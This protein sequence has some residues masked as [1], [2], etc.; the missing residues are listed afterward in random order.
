MGKKAEIAG[1]NGGR[2]NSSSHDG[3]EGGSGSGGSS[4]GSVWIGW[5]GVGAGGIEGSWGRS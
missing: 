2:L 1:P 5:I 4:G 3:G